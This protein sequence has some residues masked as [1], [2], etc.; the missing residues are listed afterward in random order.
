MF[1]REGSGNNSY[2]RSMYICFLMYADISSSDSEVKYF[3]W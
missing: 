1:S 3:D 2:Q